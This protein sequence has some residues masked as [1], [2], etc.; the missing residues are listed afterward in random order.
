MRP[1]D[2]LRLASKG[3]KP[4]EEWSQN[5]HSLGFYAVKRGTGAFLTAGASHWI[6]P[7]D[8]VGLEWNANVKLIANGTLI[9]ICFCAPRVLSA[10][11]VNQN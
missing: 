6:D 8:L 10:A 1:Q 7:G 11:R 5:R 2:E 4:G 9:G 3:L